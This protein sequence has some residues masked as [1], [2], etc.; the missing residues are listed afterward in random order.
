MEIFP[1]VHP[2]ALK[3]CCH[4]SYSQIASIHTEQSVWVTLLKH[5]F[6]LFFE[7]LCILSEAIP[8]RNNGK[9]ETRDIGEPHSIIVCCPFYV[10]VL[11]ILGVMYSHQCKIRNQSGI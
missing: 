2:S 7:F 4:S 3:L 1:P 10:S 11:K 6:L 9:K 8:L 5:G